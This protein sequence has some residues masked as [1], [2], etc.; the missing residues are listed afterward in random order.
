MLKQQ[1]TQSNFASC[2]NTTLSSCG[3]QLAA[4]SQSLFVTSHNHHNSVI[5]AQVAKEEEEHN[6]FLCRRMGRPCD[7]RFPISDR[8]GLCFW[9]ED[10]CKKDVLLIIFL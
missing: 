8:V 9:D 5:I 4:S 6:A 2:K 7:P 1:A 3:M 10:D